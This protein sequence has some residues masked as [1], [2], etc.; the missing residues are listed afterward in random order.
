MLSQALN[1][2]LG[3]EG[4]DYFQILDY[5]FEHDLNLGKIMAMP[6]KDEW[7]Y[8]NKRKLICS[9]FVIYLYKAA[10]VFGNM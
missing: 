8:D 10:G 4:L 6:E 3:T 5:A 9:S 2:R 7:R 1:K